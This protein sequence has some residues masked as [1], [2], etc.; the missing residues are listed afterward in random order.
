[1]ELEVIFPSKARSAHL[2]VAL[3][4]T[5]VRDITLT[6]FYYGGLKFTWILTIYIMFVQYR[7][8]TL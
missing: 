4:T 7:S 8:S 1:M 6:V 3:T 2:H 5:Q